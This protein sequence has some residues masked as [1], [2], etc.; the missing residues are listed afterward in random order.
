M[1]VAEVMLR[2]STP[3][4]GWKTLCATLEARVEEA[5]SALTFDAQDFRSRL[6]AVCGT[7]Q[8]AAA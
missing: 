4:Q 1:H 3:T 2:S 6:A 8:V 7:A 5:T